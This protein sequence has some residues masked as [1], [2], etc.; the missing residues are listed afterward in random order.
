[1]NGLFCNWLIFIGPCGWVSTAAIPAI[2][3]WWVAKAGSQILLYPIKTERSA[4]SS[5]NRYLVLRTRSV[6]HVAEVYLLK[7]V[8]LI[9]VYGIKHT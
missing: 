4:L 6:V 1:M 7:L 2:P 5:S 9:V 3:A 8:G